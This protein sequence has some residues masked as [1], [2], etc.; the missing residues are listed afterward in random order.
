MQELTSTV[1][2][3]KF[4]NRAFIPAFATVRLVARGGLIERQAPGCGQA[5]GDDGE[6]EDDWEMPPRWRLPDQFKPQT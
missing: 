2:Y 5:I 6:W 1:T 3:S 4:W